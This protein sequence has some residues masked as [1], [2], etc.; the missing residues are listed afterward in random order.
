MVRGQSG[1]CSSTGGIWAQPI[2]SV[3]LLPIPICGA[4]KLLKVNTANW[5]QIAMQNIGEAIAVYSL[6]S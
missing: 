2:A 3:T 1:V 5:R 6:K 4:G